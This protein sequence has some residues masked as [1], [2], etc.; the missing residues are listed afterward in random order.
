MLLAGSK[1]H[2]VPGPHFLDRLVIL[3]HPAKPL[4]D[5][6]RLTSRM[7][8]PSGARARL[9]RND[10]AIRVPPS[11]R[12]KKRIDT[13]ATGEPVCGSNHG[14]DTSCASDVHCAC[15]CLLWPLLIRGLG[16]FSL[17]LLP[18]LKNIFCYR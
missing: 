11:V 12:G 14:R 1:E 17:R 15:S 16:G 18:L 5:N 6:D 7:R 13:D 3:L 4:R 9:E 2:D 10:A 8:M